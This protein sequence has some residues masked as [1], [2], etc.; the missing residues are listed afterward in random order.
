M[1]KGFDF[2]RAHRL[3]DAIVSFR[4]AIEE[5]RTSNGEEKGEAAQLP[6]YGTQVVPEE[7]LRQLQKPKARKPGKND[8]ESPQGGQASADD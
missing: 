5:T 7:L 6:F 2:L 1:E 4:R 8:L 3:V